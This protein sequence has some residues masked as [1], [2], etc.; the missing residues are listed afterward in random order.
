MNL[1]HEGR[2]ITF[3][4]AFWKSIV[5]QDEEGPGSARPMSRV[6]NEDWAKPLM[7]ECKVDYVQ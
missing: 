1:M 5:I 7:Q 4:V 2:R 3:M 6:Q